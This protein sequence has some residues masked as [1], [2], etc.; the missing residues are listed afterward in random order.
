MIEVDSNGGCIDYNFLGVAELICSNIGTLKA[1]YDG[2]IALVALIACGLLV[3]P[4][5]NLA[6]HVSIVGYGYECVKVR[7]VLS[8]SSALIVR[9]VV[10]NVEVGIGIIESELLSVSNAVK[11]D[12]IPNTGL[13]SN[14][15]LTDGESNR[16]YSLSEGKIY[17]L[18]ILACILGLNKDGKS[19]V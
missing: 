17:K 19:G 2:I 11:V 7:P 6:S 8:R 4:E 12:G 5:V 15:V 3:E 10:N 9:A 13:K 16:V 18:Y 1:G 14:G